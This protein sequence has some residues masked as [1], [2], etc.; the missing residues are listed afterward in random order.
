MTVSLDRVELLVH[1]G[2]PNPCFVDWEEKQ[3][4]RKGTSLPGCLLSI[5]KEQAHF[6]RKLATRRKKNTVCAHMR[7][8]IT[9]RDDEFAWSTKG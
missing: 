5:I 3:Q 1:H 9:A 6:H 7:N 2:C 8:V 4:A